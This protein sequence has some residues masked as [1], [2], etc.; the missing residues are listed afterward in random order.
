M[1]YSQMYKVLFLLKMR[2]L[3]M[4][5][6]MNFIIF[7]WNYVYADFDMN[8]TEEKKSRENCSNTHKRHSHYCII[9]V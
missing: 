9:L 7:V 6:L 3:A 2:H 4:R 5:S 1:I 8:E